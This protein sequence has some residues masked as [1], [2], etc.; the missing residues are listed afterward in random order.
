MSKRYQFG[1]FVFES[2]GLELSRAGESCHCEP[3][4]LMLLDLLINNADRIVSKEEINKVVW[5]GRTVSEAALSSRIKSLRQLLNDDGKTQRYIKT[6]HKRGYRFEPGTLLE[7]ASPQANPDATLN[8]QTNHKPAVMVLPFTNLSNSTQ[9]EYLADGITTDTIAHLAKHR[10][11]SVVAR[12]TSFG[13][14]G[15]SSDIQKLGVELA[16]D[17]VV[18]GSIQLAGERI[19]V[20]VNL[21]DAS[22]GHSQWADRYDRKFE[23][24]FSLQ[25]EITEKLVAR[26][27]PEIGFSE[28]KKVLQ[29]RPANLQAWDCYHLGCYHFFLF[30]GPDNL[31]AQR[32]LKL[33]QQLDPHFGEAYC[34]WAYAVILGMVYWD[35]TPEQTLLDQALA[36]TGKALELDQHN[37]S[38]HALR[39][40]VLL[41]RKEYSKALQANETAIKLNPTFAAAHCGLGDSLAYEGRYDEAIEC[42]EHAIAL[43]PND[44]QLWAFY[45]YG[46]L[47]LIFQ[48]D[49]KRAIAW[50][51]K[52]LA[53]PNC[54]YWADA[55]QVVAYTLLGDLSAAGQCLQRVISKEPKFTLDFVEE[56]LFYLKDKSQV[57]G[58][59]GALQQAGIVP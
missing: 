16:V 14:K 32:L 24:I 13:F 18:E 39:G 29:H 6:V 15:L 41:A 55:H 42:F 25:D 43:S 57:E 22:T 20:N 3:Q 33:S 19:R 34:W 37:A 50:T 23:D 8:A 5:K 56:K 1:D 31:E 11:L 10:W 21:V 52:A 30:T 48:G 38:F 36:A 59:L 12:N 54:Q 35:T 26:L 58:Y 2:G 27:E 28:R 17:Y 40:R 7:A 53:I 45:S 49:Y 44:P 9:Q 46:A 47:S 51:D 4:V